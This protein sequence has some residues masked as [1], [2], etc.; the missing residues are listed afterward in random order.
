MT[1][2]RLQPT[3]EGYCI[4]GYRRKDIAQYFALAGDLV[5]C[6]DN[7]KI[8]AAIGQKREIDEWRLFVDSSN[9]N[10]KTGLL[11]DDNKHP[12]IP[13]AYVVHVKDT[14]KINYKKHCWN[15]GGDLKIVAILLGMELGYTKC[16]FFFFANDIADRGQEMVGETVGKM[17]ETEP[18]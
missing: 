3:A 5:Y 2:T 1:F 11:H 17:S 18:R 6:T 10:L 4:F 16:C 7:D 14:D 9:H 15:A 8:M 13:T 12:S